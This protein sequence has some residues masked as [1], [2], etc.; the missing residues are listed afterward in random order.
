MF[1]IVGPVRVGGINP[2]FINNIKDWK[3]G[4]FDFLFDEFYGF[5]LLIGFDQTVEVATI[6]EF[7]FGIGFNDVF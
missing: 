4:F 1:L 6:T 7:I 5:F 2:A 3:G